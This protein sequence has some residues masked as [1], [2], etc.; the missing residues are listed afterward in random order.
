MPVLREIGYTGDFMLEAHS[1]MR[2][3]P[4]ELWV[5]AG[6]LAYDFGMYLMNL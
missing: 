5:P 2:Q 4:R 6:K 3:V 1:Y